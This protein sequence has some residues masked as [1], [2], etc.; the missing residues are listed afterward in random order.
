MC[1]PNASQV[2]AF[3]CLKHQL[4]TSLLVYRT[5]CF[6]Q[7]QCLYWCNWIAIDTKESPT[8]SNLSF[9]FMGGV[10]KKK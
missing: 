6:L 5:H 7:V 4:A 1:P 3:V 8:C 9:S 10:E 2:V